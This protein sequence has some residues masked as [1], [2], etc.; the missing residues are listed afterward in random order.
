MSGMPAGD[1]VRATEQIKVI[2]DIPKTKPAN[3]YLELFLTS[4][5]GGLCLNFLGRAETQQIGLG[6]SALGGIG[7]IFEFINLANPYRRLFENLNL[8]I[9]EQV[10]KYLNKRNTDYGCC[11]TMT[12]PPGLST[13]DFEKHKEAIEQNL[14]TDVE[15]NYKNN[16]VFMK[17][18]NK[19]LSANQKYEFI[20]TKGIV[21]FPIGITF[22]GRIV[23]VDLEKVVHLL[24]AGQ[25]GSGKSTLVRGIITNLIM[26]KS[27]L[28][29]NRLYLHLID[30]KNGA[31]FNVFRR[32][33]IVKT[34][35]R[36]IEEA[37]TV[38]SN[39]SDEVERRYNLFFDNN[40]V[41]I[42]EYN[43]IRGVKRLPYEICIIDEFA[44][45]K[46]E[47]GS[48]E[49][50]EHLARKARAAGIH[51]ILATQRPSADII[52]GNI[53]ANVPCVI[54]L[55][56][57][58]SLNSRIII[59]QDGLESLRGK[60]H[61]YLQYGELTEFQ[62]MFLDVD[63]V[64]ELIKHTYVEKK[65]NKARVIEQVNGELDSVSL[66]ELLEVIK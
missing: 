51:L 20:E 19:K 46:T 66:N 48:L 1:K 17:I 43:R 4:F 64:K 23:T 49:M 8:S 30:L 33:R 63:H 34:F 35:S 37:E 65:K 13:K 56:T 55:K 11:I 27:K 42:K 36:T 31:E 60:G 15:F 25:T 3:S 16:R 24:I 18:Y 9:G 52:N 44:D 39:L 62:S 45:L 41:D 28:K 38:L 57:M 2:K 40:V 47:K 6:L 32:S 61:G 54:G 10:P 58:N 5:V 26:D 12:L 21:E 22:G 50:V 59:D 53:K 14:N 29:G 7:T